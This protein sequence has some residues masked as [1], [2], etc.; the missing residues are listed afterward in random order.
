MMITSGEASPRP[1]TRNARRLKILLVEDQAASAKC[2]AILLGL[3]GHH[4]DTAADGPAALRMAWAHA[5]DVV[6]LDLGLP[7]A[8]GYEVAR[9][10]KAPSPGRKPMI[11]AITGYGSDED[12]Q[13]SAEAGINMH[14]TKPV[15]PEQLR[16]VLE[17]VE[18]AVEGM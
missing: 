11:I 6:L 7:G 16:A 17:R 5:P 18:R 14:L 12:R 3:Y 15:D 9:Q 10:L 1:A 8:N 4:V 13:R 2:L